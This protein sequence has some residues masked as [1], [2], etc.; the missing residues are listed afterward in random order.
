[1]S[2]SDGA[3]RT[4][5]AQAAAHMSPAQAAQ[6]AGL[7]RWAILRAIKSQKLPA[8]RDNRGNW[9]ISQDDLQRWCGSHTSHT[10][11]DGAEL[12]V[13]APSAQDA[14]HA[15]TVAS[16]RDQLAAETARADAATSQ[17]EVATVRA[18]AAERSRDQAEGQRDH[19]QAMAT[20]LA[21]KPR[22]SW[23]PFYK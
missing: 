8:I 13:S 10:V 17:A 1:V 23:W 14:A 22:R 19:W 7:S 11:H 12:D 6:V 21:E 16:L 3:H 2:S 18:E 5:S 15:E 20:R 9:R 4:V